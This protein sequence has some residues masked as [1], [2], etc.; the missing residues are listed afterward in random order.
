MA[1][2]ADSDEG[3]DRRRLN[4]EIDRLYDQLDAHKRLKGVALA[5]QDRLALDLS[6]R[7]VKV[8]IATSVRR[9]LW[10]RARVYPHEPCAPLDLSP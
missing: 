9:E 10:E 4:E 2:D 1:E 8:G 7:G 3:R 6:Q 5:D